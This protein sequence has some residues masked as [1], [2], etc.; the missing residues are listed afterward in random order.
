MHKRHHFRGD[1]ENDKLRFDC[2][3]ANGS[4]VG[5]SREQQKTKKTRPANQYIPPARLVYSKQMPWGSEKSFVLFTTAPVDS[6][7]VPVGSRRAVAD[8]KT[9]FVGS[10]AAPVQ[11][12]CLWI[13]KQRWWALKQGLRTP[14]QRPWA[15]QTVPVGSKG[16]PLASKTALVGSKNEICTARQCLWA[17]K[18]RL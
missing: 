18:Q 8:F 7:T 2:A 9:A 3:G 13:P 10:K 16:A 5:P 4:R 6:K 17:S 1:T 15:S 14:K 11:K 12:Q